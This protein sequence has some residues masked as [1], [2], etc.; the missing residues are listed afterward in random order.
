[1]AR[2]SKSRQRELA[3]VRNKLVEAEQSGFVP[4]D[5]HAI[6]A[7]I[8]ARRARGATRTFCARKSKP[9]V[10]FKTI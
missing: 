10:S 4:P 7:E 3:L 8:K 9:A 1:M 5:R 6:L 2:R